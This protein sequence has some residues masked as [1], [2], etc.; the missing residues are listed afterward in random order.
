MERLR[1]MARKYRNGVWLFASIVL[2][3]QAIPLHMH[4][5]H[6]DDL[7]VAG[8][9]HV[10]DFHAP[11]SSTDGEHHA[12]VHIIDLN[13]QGF[14]KQLHGDAVSQLLVCLYA[15]LLLPAVR[16]LLREHQA[17]HPFLHSSC[18]AVVPPLRAPPLV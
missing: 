1:C 16:L 4:L 15:F 12:D 18:F 11:G 13:P 14:F 17:N 7:L 8:S 3:L 2:F 5:H 6:V 9:A 10:V